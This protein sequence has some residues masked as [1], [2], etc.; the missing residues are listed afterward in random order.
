MDSEHGSGDAVL[1]VT[2]LLIAHY[3][4]P[5]LSSRFGGSSMNGRLDGYTANSLG[6]F[7]SS[8]QSSLPSAA[9]AHEEADVLF[10]GELVWHF[11][12]IELSSYAMLAID[13]RHADPLPG[14]VAA[15]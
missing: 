2:D 4:A 12:A 10:D 15:M 8:K 6:R 3:P 5:L 11:F 7:G 13:S 9:A 1:E 14:A